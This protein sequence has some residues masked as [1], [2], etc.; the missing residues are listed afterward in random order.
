MFQAP[1]QEPSHSFGPGWESLTETKI[2]NFFKK[3]PVYDKRQQ[4]GTVFFGAGFSFVTR[5]LKGAT[6]QTPWEISFDGLDFRLI[7]LFLQRG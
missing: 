3:F 5:E 6:N 7:S 1:F 2:I 4:N